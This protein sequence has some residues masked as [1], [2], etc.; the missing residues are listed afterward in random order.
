[1]AHTYLTDVDFSGKATDDSCGAHIAYTFDFQGGAASGFNTP[2][3]FKS[4]DTPEISFEK[5]EALEKM[6][7]DIT[8]LRKSYLNQLMGLLG[9]AVRNKYESGWDWIYI[10][11]ADFDNGIVIFCSDYGMF[12]T[13][14]TLNGLLVEVG[15]VANPVVQTTDYQVIDGDV[16]VSLDFFD[17]L[18]DDA[19][20]NLVKGAMKFDHVKDYL[21]KASVARANKDSVI[22]E[23][24]PADG[25]NN[26]PANTSDINKGDIPLENIDKEEFLKSAEFQDLIKAQI[27]AE[28]E[29]ATAAAKAEAEAA[30][31]ELIA[32]AQAEA[33]ELRK[34]ELARVEED[35]STVIKSYD[36]VEEGKV[37]ALVKYL[38]ENKDI[39]DTIVV[40]FEKAREEVEAVKKEFGKEVGVEVTNQQEVAKSSSDL[41]RQKAAELKK[42][43]T[44]QK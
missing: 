38:I 28:V 18:I 2:L 1:M 43:K 22:A 8:E 3:L 4:S 34:A 10:V 13:D 41:I 14:F 35:Y 9:E 11:D 17:N 30:A 7:E 23:N 29:K 40:A 16:L 42:S 5:L 6:G 26:S 24:H 31:Q 19:L 15:D 33:E 20:G 12:S 21:V 39:A 25:K 44:A 27:T 37:E 32:K 36:F